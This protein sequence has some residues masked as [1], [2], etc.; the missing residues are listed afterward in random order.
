VYA[1]LAADPRVFTM[2][3]YV[4]TSVDKSLN[5]LR[6]KRLLTVNADKISRIAVLREDKKQEIEFGRNK[7]EWQ[8]LQPRPL[9]ADNQKVGAL[10]RQLTDAKMDLGPSGGQDAAAEFARAKPMVVVK[11]TDESATQELQVRRQRAGKNPDAYYVKSSA[12]DGAYKI[13]S[14][15]GRGLEK[16]LD[17]YRNPK[18]FDFNEP[19]KIELHDGSKAYF[20]TRSGEDW[21]SNGKKMDSASVQSLIG[22]LRDLT[23]VGFPDSGF[24]SPTIEAEIASEDG[25]RVEKVQMAKSDNGY[26]ARRDNEPALYR[27]DSAAV[28]DLQKAAEGT[29]LAAAT[30]K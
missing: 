3:R 18:L 30:G 23:A 27:L 2:S 1:M 12:V 22:K 28:D 4:K 9:R 16:G 14:E 13:D 25:R 24:G 6:D 15:L 19:S 8:I 7:D 11:V 26:V 20:L 10:A 29:K 21:W 17:D 5:D